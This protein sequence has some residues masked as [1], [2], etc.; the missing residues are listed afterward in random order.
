MAPLCAKCAS[1]QHIER[2][3]GEHTQHAGA[4]RGK[5]QIK[6]LGFPRHC[7]RKNFA[8]Q[9][10]VTDDG[11]IKTLE[12]F[13]NGN[14]AA[15]QRPGQAEWNVRVRMPVQTVRRALPKGMKV[16]VTIEVK[17]RDD[18]G[19]KAHLRRAFQICG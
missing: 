1:Q 4:H 11:V 17:V 15:R 18:S 3:R 6:L 7:A 10:H 9:I 19:N 16:K 12:L 13:V 2:R 5:P 8:F 14:R